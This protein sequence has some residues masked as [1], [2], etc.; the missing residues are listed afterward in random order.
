[1]ERHD[2]GP[3]HVDAKLH[4]PWTSLRQGSVLLANLGP[5]FACH[6]DRLDNNVLVLGCLDQV[7][8][9][10][11]RL[12]LLDIHVQFGA[13]DERLLLAAIAFDYPGLARSGC[14]RSQWKR[15]MRARSDARPV[16]EH[17]ADQSSRCRRMHEVKHLLLPSL[18]MVASGIADQF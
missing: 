6:G 16:M 8:D 14:V 2:G 10:A 1:M 9:G 7:L 18:G 11:A 12:D 4:S 15:V 13:Q 5:T 3:I 17:G